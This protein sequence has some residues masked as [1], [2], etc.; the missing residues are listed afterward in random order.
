MDARVIFTADMDWVQI[1][2]RGGMEVDWDAE[3]IDHADWDAACDL[4]EFDPE[5]LAVG[6]AVLKRPRPQDTL[7]RAGDIVGT[8]GGGG[9]V[10][11]LRR[12]PR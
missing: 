5:D 6:F 11:F 7:L 9:E 2:G 3:P 1:A 12:G 10:V 4:C 8:S